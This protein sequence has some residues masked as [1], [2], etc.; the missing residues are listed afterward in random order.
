MLLTHSSEYHHQKAWL[1]ET[2]LSVSVQSTHP[3]TTSQLSAM[4]NDTA[5]NILSKYNYESN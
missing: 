5:Q 4:A 1:Q 2:H 3:L